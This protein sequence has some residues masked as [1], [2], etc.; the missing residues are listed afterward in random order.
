MNQM[1]Y[2]AEGFTGAGIEWWNVSQVTNLNLMFH[3]AK[4][5]DANLSSWDVSRVKTCVLCRLMPCNLPELS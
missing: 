4:V 1:F 2:N 3:P 5:F